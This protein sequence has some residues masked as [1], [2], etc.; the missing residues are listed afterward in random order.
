MNFVSVQWLCVL[1]MWMGAGGGTVKDPRK[2]IDLC[3]YVGRVGRYSLLQ[4][5]L[6]E[7]F[8]EGI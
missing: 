3:L 1:T 8:R 4:H 5:P 7:L 2:S 6:L